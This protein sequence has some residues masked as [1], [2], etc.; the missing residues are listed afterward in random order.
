MPHRKNNLMESHSKL[1]LKTDDNLSTIS[2]MKDSQSNITWDSLLYSYLTS[3]QAI[4]VASHI[5]QTLWEWLRL[6]SK[7]LDVHSFGTTLCC[8]NVWTLTIWSGHHQYNTW[9]K[10]HLQCP[11]LKELYD[12]TKQV[13]VHILVKGM[14]SANMCLPI[15]KVWTI[16][17]YVNRSD[18]KT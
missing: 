8:I 1:E 13:R 12:F 7:L 17:Y 11:I 5:T 14:P 2:T 4:C 6:T 16:L 9:L 18:W 15:L 10:I 3:S